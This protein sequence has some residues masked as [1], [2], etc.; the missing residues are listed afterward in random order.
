VLKLKKENNSK[1]IVGH[2]S[3]VPVCIKRTVRTG[4]GP[5]V[6]KKPKSYGIDL[7]SANPAPTCVILVVC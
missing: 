5:V 7:F 4:T 1:K 3:T 2:P 6:A